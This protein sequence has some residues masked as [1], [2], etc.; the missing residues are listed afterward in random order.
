MINKAKSSSRSKI[1]WSQEGLDK[2]STVYAIGDPTSVINTDLKV[3]IGAHK[4][5]DMSWSYRS[6]MLRQSQRR[7]RSA[8][9]SS[10]WLERQAWSRPLRIPG[11]GIHK[12]NWR[13]ERS[14]P[15]QSRQVEG[16]EE[17]KSYHRRIEAR[18]PGRP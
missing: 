3:R 2:R 7:T 10:C 16:T 1:Q 12:R 13:S 17:T 8:A 11:R 18:K 9:W 6:A 5:L 4:V 14:P 15:N